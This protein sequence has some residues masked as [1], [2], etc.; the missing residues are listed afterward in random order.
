M[1]RNKSKVYSVSTQNSNQNDL[2][3]QQQTLAAAVINGGMQASTPVTDYDTL[4]IRDSTSACSRMP[5]IG[6]HENCNNS[7]ISTYSRLTYDHHGN[8]VHE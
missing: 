8:V 4:F 5:R 3:A 2:S 6:T 7:A 1:N